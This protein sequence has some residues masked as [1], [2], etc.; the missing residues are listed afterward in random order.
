MSF[1]T[2]LQPWRFGLA[3]AA[4]ALF[5]SCELLEFSPNDFRGP[6][7]QT[8]LTQ[9]NLDR[10]AENPLPA[11]DTLRFIFT[12][13]SQ[14]FYEQAE[15]LVESVNRQQGIS[16][17]VIAG[18]ISDFGLAREMR[19]V[20]NRLRK[21]TIP[22]L[23]VIGNHDHVGNGRAAYQHIFG[24]LNYSF[25][26][27][28][29][30][31]IMVDTNSREYNFNGRVPDMPWVKQQLSDLQGAKRQI[32]MSHVPPQDLDFDQTLK[33]DYTRSLAEAP[34]L[35][36]ELNGHRHDFSIGEP[37]EDGVTYINSYAFEENQYVILTLWNDADDEPQFRL[38]KVRF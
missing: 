37:F 2:L 15:A 38:K 14:R 3:V 28:D 29:T 33:E 17:M 9:K 5:S 35:V 1:S 31:F 11:G 22:Y 4:T 19:W 24:P 36:F 12:G 34:K 32:V 30:K 10:L 18:D 21:L 26:Y 7:S 16:L 8:N 20:D 23:T 13:D 27:G 6:A 25:V